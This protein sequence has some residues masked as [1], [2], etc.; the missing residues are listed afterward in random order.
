MLPTKNKIQLVLFSYVGFR[1]VFFNVGKYPRKSINIF[2]NSSKAAD[3]RMIDITRLNKDPK[4]HILS[5]LF[6]LD[7]SPNFIDRMATVKGPI[8]KTIGTQIVDLAPT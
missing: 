5:T 8:K 2:M 4:R 6:N 3:F 1:N 7:P